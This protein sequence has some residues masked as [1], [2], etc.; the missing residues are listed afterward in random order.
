MD[1]LKVGYLVEG[2]FLAH[3]KQRP[4]GISLYNFKLNP[5][6]GLRPRRFFKAVIGSEARANVFE[7]GLQQGNLHGIGPMEGNAPGGLRG[8]WLGVRRR[9]DRAIDDL[10]PFNAIQGARGVW[11]R[12]YGLYRCNRRSLLPLT[13]WHLI[14]V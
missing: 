14:S 10:R 13:A 9:I 2:L 5:F 7:E 1:G 8:R 4:I 3:D 6:A 12:L 11:R